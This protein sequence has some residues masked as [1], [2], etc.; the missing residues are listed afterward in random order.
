MASPW[1]HLPAELLHRVA[2]LLDNK[3]RRAR[4][5]QAALLRPQGRVAPAVRGLPPPPL[6]VA[7]PL[8]ARP[9]HRAHLRPLLRHRTAS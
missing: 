2:G 1:A 4:G 9:Q 8:V 7:L 6:A 3:G 5:C